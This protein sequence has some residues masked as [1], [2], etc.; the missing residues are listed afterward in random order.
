MPFGL[1]SYLAL[2]LAKNTALRG[3]IHAPSSA[4]VCGLSGCFRLEMAPELGLGFWLLI[5]WRF[6]WGIASLMRDT[7]SG[8]KPALCD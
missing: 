6:A 1:H 5:A 8:T 7:G 4:S 3:N 2:G